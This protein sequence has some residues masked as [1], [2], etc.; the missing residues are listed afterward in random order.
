VQGHAVD[1]DQ[2]LGIAASHVVTRQ[3]D[4]PLDEVIV[5]QADAEQPDH[6]VPETD[7]RL[8]RGRRRRQPRAGAVEHHDVAPVDAAEVVDEL[9]D[10]EPVADIERV[11]H[12]R[13]RDPEGLHHVG[14]DQQCQHER[15]HD[16]DR[17][18]G[19]EGS[20]FPRPGA[21][22]PVSRL[23]LPGSG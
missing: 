18:L 5:R 6:R 21:A 2:A 13:R 23:L 12:R 11:L 20:A 17:Q 16:Q 22:C 4:H 1:R 3:P 10:Q 15:E 7:Q 19:P 8:G 14:L 9:V